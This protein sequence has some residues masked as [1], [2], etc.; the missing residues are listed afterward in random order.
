MT[1][2]LILMLLLLTAV[3]GGIFG[4]K[5]QQNQQMAAGRA[6]GPPPAT[7]AV[8]T[9]Q[10]EVWRPYLSAVG[11]LAAVS[12]IQVTSEVAG[13]ISAIHFE[14]GQTVEA[15]DVLV[16]LDDRT[17]QASLKGLQAEQRLAKLRFKRVERLVREKSASRSDFDEARATLDN[18][19]AQVAAQQALIDKKRIRAPFAGRLGIRLVDLGEYMP[20]GAPIVPLEALDPIYADFSLPERELS[21]V[22]VGQAIEVRVQPFPDQTFMG[23]I[24]AIDPG[25]DRGTR[26][27]RLRATLPNGDETLRPGLFAE[28]RVKL[29]REDRV[30]TVPRTAVTYNP[31]GDSVFVVVEG[32]DGMTVQRRQIETG[33]SRQGRIVVRGGLRAGDRIV[34]AGQVKLRNGQAIVIDDKPAPSERVAAQ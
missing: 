10:E 31:Y 25:M 8:A 14:S 26:S 13:Q 3:F 7:V 28:V 1:A 9:V 2:R 18:A 29:G 24:S 19:T 5:W 33:E 16:Q 20:P 21:Q 17:D 22:Q 32:D 34:S 23:R 27:L 6:G 11:S 12:G 30:L 4:W 15:G